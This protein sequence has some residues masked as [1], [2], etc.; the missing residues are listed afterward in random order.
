MLDPELIQM[1]AC[2]ACPERPPVK[3]GEDS[4]FLI[5]SECGRR[6]PVE[7]DIPIM[8]VE[9]ALAPGADPASGQGGV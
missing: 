9:E 3:L 5:C 8:L 2:P 7:D 4:S 6:Y 1:L